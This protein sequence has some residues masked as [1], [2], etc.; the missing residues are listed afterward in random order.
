MKK[1]FFGCIFCVLAFCCITSCDL[2]FLMLF[3][4]N[5]Y[6]TITYYNPDG[7]KYDS[8]HVEKNS[9]IRDFEYPTND[10]TFIGWST[11]QT[12]FCLFDFVQ[13]ISHDLDLY[14]VVAPNVTSFDALFMDGCVLNTG[15]R[16]NP[17]F[18]A[19]TV[20]ATYVS[21]FDKQEESLSLSYLKAEN[22]LLYFVFP[23]FDYIENT[24]YTVKV[25]I[26]KDRY[27]DYDEFS[28]TITAVAPLAVSNLRAE[29]EDSA[30]T[31][32]WTA[33]S[34]F[35][36]TVEIYSGS[37]LISIKQKQTSPCSFYGLKNNTTYRFKV[38][39]SC[40]NSETSTEITATPLIATKKVSDYLMIMYMD[41]DN[42]LNDAIY[43]DLNE[44]EKGLA[45]IKNADGSAKSGYATIN[46]VALWDGYHQSSFTESKKE[47]SYILELAGD[48]RSPYYDAE[49]YDSLGIQLQSKNL[50]YTAHW[51]VAD[52]ETSS[53]ELCGEVN[54]GD[55]ATLANFLQWVNERYEADKTILQFSN[56]GGGPRS[57]SRMGTTQNGIPLVV[58]DYGRRA[59]CWDYTSD[60]KNAYLT[61][62][63]VEEAL[64]EAGFGKN[65]KLDLLL[66][67]VC[68]GASIEDS[69]QFR[70]YAYYLAA[71][72]N[73]VPGLGNDYISLLESFTTNSSIE[74]IADSL[75]VS[76]KRDYTLSE[77]E[78][79]KII[80]EYLKYGYTAEQIPRFYTGANTYSIIDLTKIDAIYEAI[81]DFAQV[82]LSSEGRKAYKGV[83]D[84][85]GQPITRTYSEHIRDTIFTAGYP[86]TYAGS[87]TYLFDIGKAV[88]YVL[89][90]FAETTNDGSFNTNY[91]SVLCESAKNVQNAL[92][93]ALIR[94]W[95]DRCYDSGISEDE[96]DQ[97]YGL[98]IAGS[99]LK[100]QNG[101]YVNGLYPSFY[102][103]DL[104]FGTNAWADVLEMWF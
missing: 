80:A 99:T 39:T 22:G 68:L 44:V 50:S 72:P 49:H 67:D 79:K 78:W 92:D 81:D 2:I 85:N 35:T 65:N 70:N 98:T 19:F 20:E 43:L 60:E 74:S 28:K 87:F 37:T 91:S 103:T 90:D 66:M 36:N 24:S 47:G 104:A 76:Y 82:I 63:D 48:E 77:S 46:V 12:S 88:Y 31:L 40:G 83:T 8:K 69:Y 26:L 5:N 11:S 21:D 13:N 33:G 71:S 41:G 93:A 59:L 30:V 17:N 25:R 15:T 52:I 3:P 64:A 9:V 73:I 96:N 102:K 94:A 58:K 45:N 29:T 23:T 1:R 27:G 95:R 34:T 100:T 75:L 42:D 101:T 55:K 51:L 14:A 61:T 18:S 6:C 4:E 56:H 54:M 10:G 84:T 38:I 53:T 16:N 7:T 89:Q 62:K 97:T 32:T 57:V 86:F